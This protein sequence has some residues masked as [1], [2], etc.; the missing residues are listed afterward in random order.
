MSM[1][2]NLKKTQK[3]A[4]FLDDE[5]DMDIDNMDFP[6]PSDAPSSSSRPNVGGG[7]PN[8]GASGM[9]DM[10]QLQKMMQSMGGAGGLGDMMGGMGGMGSMGEAQ[11]PAATSQ[12]PGFVSVATGPGGNIRRMSPEEY[13]DW[14]C[15]YPCYIDADKSVQDGRKISKEKAVNNPH[16]YHMSIACQKLGFSAVYE[17]KRHPRDWANVGRVRVQM[18]NSA[19]FFIHE[20]IITRKQLFITIAKLL[21]GIQKEG[22]V[23]KSIV[24]PLTT[25]AEIEALAD[26]Q[27]KAQGL[28]TLS[29][30]TAQQQAIQPPAVPAKAKKQ[31]VKYVRG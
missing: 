19:N 3:N 25:L 23:P 9:P 5:D 31:K 6:L 13:K 24:S 18:K 11:R 26:E 7:M 22:D 20:D 1:L 27:R 30:M 16:A 28:P 10:A 2:N 21:P 15:V 4:V 17:N 14:V 29:E 8:L 12:N